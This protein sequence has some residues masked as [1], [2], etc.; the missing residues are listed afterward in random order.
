MPFGWLGAGAVT[1]GVGAAMFAG[2]GTAHAD[3]SG[4]AS[5]P[6]RSKSAAHSAPRQHV[7][8]RTTGASR[9]KLSA[10]PARPSAGTPTRAAATPAVAAGPRHISSGGELFLG[11]NYIELGLSSVGSFGTTTGKPTG[12]VGGTPPGSHPNSVGFVFDVDG[13][14][15]GAD[16]ALDF[17]VPDTPEERWSVGYNNTNYGGFSALDG[18]LTN[19]SGLADISVSDSSSGST[20]SGVF[21]GTVGDAL[22]V[23]QLHTFKVND[24][25]Y[26]TTVTLTNVSGATLQNV[27]FMRSFDPDGTRSVGG[28]NS[29]VNTI[30]GQYGTDTFASVI[31]ASLEGDAYQVQTGSRAVA[32]FYSTDPRSVVYTGGFTNPNPYDFANANQATG[33]TTTADDAIGIIFKL[34]DLA[35]NATVKFSYYTGATTDDDLKLIE[36]ET[37]AR[38][39]KTIASINPFITKF[40]SYIESDEYKNWMTAVG[41]IASVIGIKAISTAVNFVNAAVHVYKGDLFAAGMDGVQAAGDGLMALGAKS[42]IGFLYAAGAAVSTIGY[43][44]ELAHETDWSDPG[45]TIQYA[46][47]HPAETITEFTKATVAVGAHV[48]ATV[49]GSFGGFLGIVKK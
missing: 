3:D 11:G 35:P 8:D 20:L 42:N 9:I 31:A 25:Y 2:G 10:P 7:A 32:Y 44:A 40:N 19:T 24:N 37:D 47:K 6:A 28:V 14:G 15:T 45:G 41:G 36:D 12:F 29:T 1:A 38:P 39:I 18:N 48:A 33:Y 4:Q 16:K 17:Y 49:F 34:G 46:V 5:A 22:R 26:K 43:V 21:T 23:S 13:F 27:E 30:L